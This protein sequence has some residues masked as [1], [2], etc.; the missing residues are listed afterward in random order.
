MSAASTKAA[1]LVRPDE[2]TPRIA[3]WD[4]PLAAPNIEDARIAHRLAGLA[5][6]PG[7]GRIEAAYRRNLRLKSWQYMTAVCDDLFIA[8]VVGTAGFASNG[9]VYAAELPNGRVHKRFAIAPFTAGTELAPSSTGG[10]HRF[11]SRGLLVAIDNAG[12]QFRA[13]VRARTEAGGELA[14]DLA[15]TSAERDEHLAVCVPLPEGRWNYT[16]K[17]AAFNVEGSVVVDGRRID[18]APGRS[19]GTLDFTK[20]FA[21]RHAVWRWIAVSGRTRDGRVIGLNLVDPTPTAPI[22]EN[23]AWLDGKRYPLEGVAIAHDMRTCQASGLELAM[24]EVAVVEQKLDVPLVRHR[25]RHVVG[26]F[27]GRVMLAGDTHEIDSLVGIAEDY[28]TWW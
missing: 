26:A 20:M 23:A 27:T 14:A 12:R 19:F 10:S 15:F 4:E 17:F 28:D 3:A 6:L 5:G 7:L 18:F 13:D 21:L 22:S 16:H 1:D 2:T 24:R 25:L 11:R 9:F 8:F